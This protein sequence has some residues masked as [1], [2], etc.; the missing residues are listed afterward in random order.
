MKLPIYTPQVAP[1]NEAPGRAFQV[2][3]NANLEAQTQLSKGVPLSQALSEVSQF[4]KVRIE[5]A[6][7]NLLNQ[8]TLG[9]D[10]KIFEAFKEL[11][12]SNDFNRVLDGEN[13]LWNEK[14]IK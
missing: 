10:E 5:M 8:A 6:R 9:A 2:R 12:E 1:T 14:I 13:P 7:D 11:S 4:S 3:R